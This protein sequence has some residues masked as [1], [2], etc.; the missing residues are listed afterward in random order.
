MHQKGGEKGHDH[1]E[2]KNPSSSG[3][4][5]HFYVKHL[6][7]H[8]ERDLFAQTLKKRDYYKTK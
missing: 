3:V 7:R 8:H 1:Q 5:G 4:Y 2:K 6:I